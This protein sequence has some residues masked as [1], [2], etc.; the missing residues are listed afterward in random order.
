M[1]NWHF[2][3]RMAL[4]EH[5]WIFQNGKASSCQFLFLY[6]VCTSRYFSLMMLLNKRSGGQQTLWE[7]F[8]GD[9]EYPYQIS[10]NLAGSCLDICNWL[11]DII[12]DNSVQKTYLRFKK[13]I[14]KV[15]R[16]ITIVLCWATTP[17][18][19]TGQA[20]SGRWQRCSAYR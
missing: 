8:S 20:G 13:N 6:L 10:F 2:V 1:H 3:L 9:H 17:L 12:W 19:A 4:D 11:T 15:F 14:P 7:S 16:V 5:F 18:W